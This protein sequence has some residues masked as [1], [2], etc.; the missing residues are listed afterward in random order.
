[1]HEAIVNR[2]GFARFSLEI[3]KAEPWKVLKVCEWGGKF[4][5]LF[6]KNFSESFLKFV[7]SSPLACLFNAVTAI[8]TIQRYT[9]STWFRERRERMKNRRCVEEIF[10]NVF[11]YLN[12]F[13]F[14]FHDTSFSKKERKREMSFKGWKRNINFLP[15]NV[16]S[17]FSLLSLLISHWSDKH[18]K[19]LFDKKSHLI[20]FIF[21][22]LQHDTLMEGS[23]GKRWFAKV[24]WKAQ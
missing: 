9:T 20:T 22:L 15:R 16:S 5:S 21:L 1:M 8:N 10:Y 7:S 13:F 23:K 18:I 19:F 3:T 14:C 2:L 6:N 11:K 17:L 24:P 4:L 12:M